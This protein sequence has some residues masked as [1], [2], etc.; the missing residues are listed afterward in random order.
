[1]IHIS[2]SN[3]M[4]EA[5][6]NES[7]PRKE[8]LSDKNTRAEPMEEGEVNEIQESCSAL[9]VNEQLDDSMPRKENE[10]GKRKFH[11]EVEIRENDTH[12]SYERLFGR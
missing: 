8:Y 9:Q 6:K 11:Q 5:I 2:D 3:K 1:M 12:W 10:S 7:Y 4:T